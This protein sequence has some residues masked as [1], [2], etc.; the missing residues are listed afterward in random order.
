MFDREFTWRN[1][2]PPRAGGSGRHSLLRRRSTRERTARQRGYLERRF[3]G[4]LTV[5]LTAR[6]FFHSGHEGGL[7]NDA[8]GQPGYWHE[9]LYVLPPTPSGVRVQGEREAQ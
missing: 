7:V 9:A 8:V 3:F 2:E 6:N 1:E 4:C 5:P